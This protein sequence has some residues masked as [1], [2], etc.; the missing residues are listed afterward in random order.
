M[1]E[2]LVSVCWARVRTMQMCSSL[3]AVQV[4]RGIARCVR[5]P[6][7]VKFGNLCLWPKGAPGNNVTRAPRPLPTCSGGLADLDN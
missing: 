2:A 3:A 1:R 5:H 4:A 7:A 6:N